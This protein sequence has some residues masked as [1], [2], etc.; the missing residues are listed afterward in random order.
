MGQDGRTDA[1]GIVMNI[2]KAL[3]GALVVSATVPVSE[4]VADITVSADATANMECSAGICAPTAPDAVLNVGDLEGLLAGGNVE[5]TTTGTGVEAGSIQL[6]APL[7]WSTGSGLTL[8]AY[9][10][11]MVGARVTVADTGGLSVLTSQ[12]GSSG[13]FLFR[14]QGNVSFAT[15][16]SPLS[17]NG[18]GYTLV[19]SL[20][21]L[22]KAIAANPSGAYAL[23]SS[24]DAS[25]DG[26]YTA[27]PIR[28]TF[29]GSFNGLG[30]AISNLVIAGNGVGKLTGLFALVDTTGVVA[31]LRLANES[32][33]VSE[34]KRG[35]IVGGL[36]GDNFG[37]LFNSS[38][39]G[40]IQVA[41]LRGGFLGGVVGL[42]LG[43]IEDVSSDV[44]VHISAN[45][46]LNLYAGGLAGDSNG[47]TVSES[48]SKKGISVTAQG[49]NYLIGG[50]FG[51]SSGIVKNCYAKGPVR[52]GESAGTGYVG[53][54]TGFNQ[55]TVS[56]S[57][58]T[59]A[60]S[61]GEG[62]DIGGSLG[63][64][65]GAGGS[66]RLKNVYWDTETSG[67]GKK[68]GAGNIRND[69][70]LTGRTTKQLTAG[71]PKGFDDTVWAQD[72]KIN[73]GL[74]YLINNPPN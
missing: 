42:S 48:F 58:S 61:A 67:I 41:I 53:G 36:E 59:G 29:E 16:S 71:L 28:K 69:K 15:T 27:S 12:G 54:F 72:P 8:D 63:Y 62:N 43:D 10:S 9:R 45:K 57:Y 64:D 44:S 46:K 34:G 17:I 13:V 38:V 50:L 26:A 2:R 24:Y 4:A 31:S 73:Q 49:L 14:P 22:A 47:G 39:S 74:P 52:L 30:N 51:V 25:H 70:G 35:E 68:Q 5:I 11:V 23:S 3:L 33:N 65:D 32:I 6:A 56:G 21:S 37:Y 66:G 19:K 55:A 7:T 1:G 60:P 20:H 18:I 40:K